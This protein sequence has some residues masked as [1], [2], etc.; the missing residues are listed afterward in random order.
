MDVNIEFAE[1]MAE[2]L[3]IFNG[4]VSELARQAGIK[5][6]SAK[7]WLTGESDPQMSN[8]VKLARAAGVN[9]QWLAT[10]EGAQYPNQTPESV[11]QNEDVIMQA[12]FQNSLH[13]TDELLALLQA[14]KR[15]ERASVNG[16]N[17]LCDTRGN[18]VDI[19]DFVFIPYYNVELSAGR[20]SWV[21]SEE[22]THSLAFR[23]DWLRRFVRAPLDKLSVVKVKGDSMVNVFNDKD[24][25]LI[26]HTQVEPHDG[27]YAIRLGNDVFVKRLQR[28]VNK[29]VI[30]SAN[31][32]YPPFEINLD[33]EN[34]AVI[35]RVVWLGR[36]L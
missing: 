17:G 12:A 28:L 29:V 23:A 3:K 32:E 5:P 6:P 22:P 2:V 14:N 7:R 31:P 16:I 24:T 9:V 18:P 4:N 35:G 8:L 1:R 27:L 33:D 26:D 20:G 30:I 25:I 13:K 21:E 11:Q 36:L 34:F 19:D 15:K 10:G